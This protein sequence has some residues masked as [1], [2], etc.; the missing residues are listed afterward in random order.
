MLD[1]FCPLPWNHVSTLTN[2]D[3][4]VCCLCIH[5]PWGFLKKSDGSAFNMAKDDLQEAQNA[6]I[7]K[8]IRKEMLAGKKPADCNL[9]WESEAL[10]QSSRRIQKLNEVDKSLFVK[11]KHFTHE[12][13]EIDP[14]AFPVTYLDLRLGNMCN[15][16]CRMCGPTDSNAW[17]SDY[18]KLE[19]DE[20][21]QVSSFKYYENSYDLEPKGKSAWNPNTNDFNWSE[22]PNFLK[23]LD[24]ALEN[25]DSLYFTGGEPTII[26][27]HWE[28]LK[29]CIDR[30]L[31]SKIILEYNT[32]MSQITENYLE[33]WSHFKNV[34]IGCSIDGMGKLAAYLR[35]PVEWTVIEDNLLKLARAKQ[36]HNSYLATTLSAFNVLGYLDLIEY[37]LTIKSPNLQTLPTC[38][39]LEYP[40]CYSMQI[41]SPKAKELILSKYQALSDKISDHLNS[42]EEAK[43]KRDFASIKT[44]L[45]AE[46]HSH[47]IKEFYRRTDKLD[48]IRGQ[49]FT[50]VLPEIHQLLQLK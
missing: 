2:G 20:S 42:D 7:L 22:N 10:G 16:R 47:M 4:R 28:L 38:H 27:A 8:R 17:Y 45:L 34:I 43:L 37:N 49:S 21:N 35:P 40:A 44:F 46:D 13:G 19:S 25:I 26:K 11:A 39:F 9:C 36:S 29:L 50:E 30:G 1:T 23:Q 14:R 18:V 31:A 6:E 33:I 24:A 3:M 41:F 15:L 32:N 12:D 48:Q 5:E